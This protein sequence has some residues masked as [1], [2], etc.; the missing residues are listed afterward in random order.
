MFI[1]K[2]RWK[3]N[4]TKKSLKNVKFLKG[5]MWCEEGEWQKCKLAVRGVGVGVVCVAWGFINACT[6]V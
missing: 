5:K 4:V 2:N 1:N 6:V 3:K